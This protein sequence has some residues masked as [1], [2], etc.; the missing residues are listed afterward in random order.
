M[1][2]KV[3][4]NNSNTIILSQYKICRFFEFVTHYYWIPQRRILYYGSNTVLH[5]Q[6]SICFGAKLVFL[7]HFSNTKNI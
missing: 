5:R 4:H 7:E 6:F 3:L 1:A 2:I